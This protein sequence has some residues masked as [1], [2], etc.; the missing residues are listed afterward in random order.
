MF[1]MANHRLKN[2]EVDT[3]EQLYLTRLFEDDYKRTIFM[4]PKEQQRRIAI[5]S[6][7]GSDKKVIDDA[8]KGFDYLK[9]QDPFAPLH[10][11]F[12]NTWGGQ[13]LMQM[14]APNFEIAMLL[15]KL[16]GS[17][18]ATDSQFRWKEIMNTSLLRG[19][20]HADIEN[21]MSRFDY[22]W[23]ID[24]ETVFGLR[25]QGKGREIR[26]A[27]KEILAASVNQ[28]PLSSER[29]A[30]ILKDLL[31]GHKEIMNE[32]GESE[33]LIPQRLK[34][35]MPLDGFTH[36]NV[37]RLLVTHGMENSLSCVPMAVLFG[38]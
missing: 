26:Q 19:S 4:L 35:V 25:M 2:I 20:A 16:T 24:H 14:N 12:F 31:N 15:T 6:M 28:T 30:R 37:Q 32:F 17:A 27:H 34:F 7:P 8:L 11:S 18:F 13:L 36:R 5:E 9:K 29:K 21:A 10:N 22:A 33:T 38:V 23:D 3:K 1:E